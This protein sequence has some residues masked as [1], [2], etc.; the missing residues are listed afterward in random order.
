MAGLEYMVFPVV[1][2]DAPIRYRGIVER[3]LKAIVEK[4]TETNRQVVFLKLGGEQ[5]ILEFHMQNRG[6]G[7]P[8]RGGRHARADDDAAE[9]RR[10]SRGESGCRHK[11]EIKRG[12]ALYGKQQDQHDAAA[13]LGA[14][15]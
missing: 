13:P 3:K 11:E 9:A 14:H 10:V 8:G 5:N 12:Y 2:S 15:G 6:E 4:C 1:R 7:E